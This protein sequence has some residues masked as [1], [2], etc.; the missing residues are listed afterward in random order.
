[1]N[2]RN[3]IV[4]KKNLFLLLDRKTQEQPKK[5]SKDISGFRDLDAM[6]DFLLEVIFFF[7]NFL[8]G[9]KA[10]IFLCMSF[11]WNVISHMLW[12]G[13]IIRVSNRTTMCLDC[14]VYVCYGTALW[15]LSPSLLFVEVL[16]QDCKIS[17]KAVCAHAGAAFILGTKCWSIQKGRSSLLASSQEMHRNWVEGVTIEEILCNI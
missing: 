1:M 13:I 11:I 2:T 9:A 6:L 15:L 5:A 8:H 10:L 14:C 12:V 4:L 7:F 16:T 3:H 17:C